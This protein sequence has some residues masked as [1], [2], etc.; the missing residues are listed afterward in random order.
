M[1]ENVRKCERECKHTK[2]ILI[3]ANP[4]RIRVHSVVSAQT[5]AVPPFSVWMSKDRER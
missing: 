2:Y 5:S 3:I 1:L 4:V